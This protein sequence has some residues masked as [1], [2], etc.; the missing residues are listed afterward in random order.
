MEFRTK[1]VIGRKNK[2]AY[3]AY[4]GLFI[5]ISSLVLVFIPGMQDYIAWVFGAGIVVV[6]IGAV[7]ARGDVTDYGLGV[8]ELTVSVKGITIGAQFYPMDQIRKLDF[9]VQAFE[10]MY[11]NDGAM[12]SGSSS[13]GMT[14]RVSFQVN[15]RSVTS[16]FYLGSA[17][18]VQLLGAVFQEFYE[19][20][21]PFIEHNKNAQTY[22]FQYLTGK[23]LEAFKIKY[24][25]K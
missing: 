9:D 14:N 1:T 13:D 20:H 16:G 23:E 18:H 12:V 7:I 6:V 5:A 10:G 21:L 4:L 17:Q 22:L 19:L 15:G 11:V 24:G 25:Y 3:I 8:D 2:K